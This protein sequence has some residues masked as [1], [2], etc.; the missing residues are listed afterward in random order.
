ML[1][2]THR[3]RKVVMLIDEYDA[4][5]HAGYVSGYKREILDFFRA[6]FIEG[7]KGNPHLF[8]GVLT[9]ILRVARESIFSGLNNLRVY[10]LLHPR[11]ATA[12]G[13]TEAEVVSLLERAELPS[14]WVRCRPGMTV[15][16]S[17]AR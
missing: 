6:F 3:V 11:F 4:P 5:I 15:M 14:A 17:A 8:K 16:S 10:S 2:A 1:S 7:L 13:F 9:G 12:F